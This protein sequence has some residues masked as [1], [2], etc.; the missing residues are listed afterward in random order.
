MPSIKN[1]VFGDSSVV[2]SD[3]RISFLAYF[4]CTLAIMSRGCLYVFY[5]ILVQP[6]FVFSDFFTQILYLCM[7]NTQKQDMMVHLR[8]SL[9]RKKRN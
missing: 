3:L 6:L 1:P 7:I 9:M 2:H 4:D 8:Y 5:P